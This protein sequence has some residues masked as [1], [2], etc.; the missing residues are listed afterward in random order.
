MQDEHDALEVADGA[1]SDSDLDRLLASAAELAAIAQD[2][3]EAGRAAALAER[4]R[5]GRFVIAVVGEFKRGKSTLVNALLGEDVVPT[6]VL[7][8][9]AVSIEISHG[10]PSTVVEFLDGSRQ[11]IDRS[12]LAGYVSEELNPS[13]TKGVARVLVRGPWP[14]LRGGV[15]LVDTPGIGSIHQHNTA[16]AG[17]ALI[18][19]DG[20]VVV[21]SADSP[22]SAAEREMLVGLRAREARTFF[23]L[24]KVDH[25]AAA[26]VLEVRNFVSEAISESLGHREPVFEVDARAARNDGEELFDFHALVDTLADFL[27]EELV[28]TQ[29]RRVRYELAQLGRSLRDSLS[30]EEAAVTLAVEDLDQ[31]TAAFSGAAE[32]QRQEFDDDCILLRRDVQ[33][34]TA[35]A[36][37]ELRSWAQSEPAKWKARLD[38][39]AE[40]GATR[41]L[42]V[43]LRA[44]IESSVKEA[45]EGF[46]YQMADT[47]DQAWL[48]A[49]ERFRQ[50]TEERV[51]AIRA[52]AA[53]LFT[54][55]LSRVEIPKV[56]S[57]KDQFSY[58]FVRVGSSTDLVVDAASVLVPRRMARR[59][60]R[61]QAGQELAREFDK[62]AGRAGW[63]LAQRLEEAR[64]ELEQAMAAQ[65]AVSVTAIEQASRRAAQRR[66][67]AGSQQARWSEESQHLATV[68][69]QLAGL[70]PG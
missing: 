13:N 19:A 65:V 29:V 7:P 37:T 61:R 51:A 45:F 42:D 53:E 5:T 32:E 24:N 3:P 35:E 44:V 11:L 28:A 6:G 17:Q 31:L 59:R 67:A 66:A 40:Q 62:H 22:L 47:V 55:E 49:A 8:L 60:A 2:R 64:R 57:R 70:Q 54:I 21:F 41:H 16:A 12:A 23:V 52:A 14:L 9:T 46:R 48:A 68:A 18:E 39:A 33:R 56:T 26:E 50:R 20:A 10:D 69:D 15:T 36:R 1:G 34:L 38:E 43:A 25:L 30:L 63:D 4:I 58:L 27:A